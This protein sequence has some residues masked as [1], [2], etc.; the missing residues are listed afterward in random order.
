[1]GGDL[2]LGRGVDQILAHPSEPQLFESYHSALDYVELAE[3]VGG[4]IPRAVCAD[5]IWGDALAEME[6]VRPDVRIVNLETAITTSDDAWPQKGIHYRM[7]PAN[8]PVLAA[9]RVNCCVLANN[10]VLDWGR[11]GLA[12]TLRCLRAGGIHVAGAGVDDTEAAAPAVIVVTD[13]L[14]VVV[15]AFATQDSGVP[16]EWSATEQRAG[17]NLIEDLSARSM[18]WITKQIGEHS[19]HGNIVVAS[20][21]WGGNWGYGISR[22]QRDFAHRLIDTAGVD[23]VHG[24]SSHHAK[25]I[26]VYQRKGIMYGC[27]DLLNDYEGI[28]GHEDYRGDLG[29]MYFPVLDAENGDLVQLTMTPVGMRGFRIS[30]APIADARWL[31]TTMHR[32]CQ[33]LGAGVVS[34]PDGTLQLR[35]LAQVADAMTTMGA[36]QARQ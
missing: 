28:N 9:G 1:L 19:G 6:R 12:E 34:Q 24:H 32:E 10:H 2:M 29:L 17:V 13:S 15:H 18:A 25:G 14:R 11:T 21:H 26:E 33:K 35:W 5:Y 8:L 7:H 16:R 36:H 22:H 27:G 4:P 3:R 30:R 20:I 31:G 23:L